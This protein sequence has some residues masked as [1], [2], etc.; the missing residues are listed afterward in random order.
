MMSLFNHHIITIMN[1]QKILYI[2]CC[3]LLSTSHLIKA[4]EVVESSMLTIDRIFNSG[5]FRRDF[6]RPIQWIENG[7]AYVTIESSSTEAGGDE[8][9]RYDSKTQNR[10]LFVGAEALTIAGKSLPIESFSLSWRHQSVDLYQF[11]PCMAFQYQRGLLGIWPGKQT[12][13]TTGKNIWI[14]LP[15]VCQIFCRQ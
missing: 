5:E 10:T 12:I 2:F 11:E 3:L 1:R 9:I 7:A 13:K 4:Q 15:D 8:L 6:Q 14:F